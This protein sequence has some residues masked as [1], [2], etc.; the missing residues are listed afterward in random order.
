MVRGCLTKYYEL[1]EKMYLS[2]YWTWASEFLNDGLVLQ[3]PPFD[4][5]HLQGDPKGK[6]ID[7]KTDAIM[8]DSDA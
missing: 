1:L 4:P 6:R 8:S 5:L 7:S 2:I 3:K